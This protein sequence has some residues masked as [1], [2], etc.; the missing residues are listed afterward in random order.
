MWDN[1]LVSGGMTAFIQWLNLNLK[2]PVTAQQQKKQGQ[3][4]V[5][6]II[7]TDGSTADIKVSK[8]SGNTGT[9]L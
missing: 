2:Y 4:T 5:T 3:V 1:F 8:T 6:F 9:R 7:N